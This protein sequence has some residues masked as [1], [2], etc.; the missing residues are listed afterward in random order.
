[1]RGCPNYT[2]KKSIL[3]CSFCGEGIYDGEKYIENE[4]GDC[5][6]FDCFYNTN[7][8]LEWIGYDIKTMEDLHD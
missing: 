5:R 4:F 8:L 2:P 7:E 6:H 1:M 3:Y